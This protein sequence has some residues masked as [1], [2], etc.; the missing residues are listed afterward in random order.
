[1]IAS[2]KYDVLRGAQVID[3]DGVDAKSGDRDAFARSN[4]LVK[5]IRTVALSACK[6]FDIRLSKSDTEQC[7]N[8]SNSV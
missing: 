1:M 2:H 4:G 6:A 5:L 8:S 7:K 3:C